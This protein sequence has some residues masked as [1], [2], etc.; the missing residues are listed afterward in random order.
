MS[1]SV[2]DLIPQFDIAKT[3][4]ALFIGINI[5]AILFGLNNVQALIYFQTHRGTGMI[6]YKLVVIWLWILDALHLAFIVHCVY[7]YLVIKY[8]NINVLTE[9]VWSFKLQIV[10]EVFI[11]YGVHLLYVYRIWLLSKGRSRSLPI[12]VGIIITLNSAIGIALFWAIYQCYV[13]S[14]LI[15]I[16][17]FT[18]M[19]L[20]TITFADIVIASSLCYLLATSRTGFSNTD[21]LI[22]KL[23]VYVISTGCLT[24]VCSMAAMIT[25]AVMPTNFIFLAVEFSLAKLYINSYLALLNARYYGQ[26]NTDTNNSYS[27]YNRHEVYHPELHIGAL[28][29]GELRVPRKDVFKHPDDEAAESSRSVKP[30]RPMAVRMETMEMNSFSPV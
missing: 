22:T 10:F 9:I 6:F 17:W 18:F 19:T 30:Q 25:C 24:S 11:I 1:S 26:V 5:A 12:A 15:N 13:F 20:G 8:A 7:Y 2:Q 21:S 16:E 4:G 27:S 23:M 3:F 14:D 28:E 29:D